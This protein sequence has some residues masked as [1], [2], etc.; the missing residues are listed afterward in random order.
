MKKWII[1]SACILTFSGY[2]AAQSTSAKATV[3]PTAKASKKG[4]EA[5]APVKKSN[6]KTT[7]EPIKLT[8][9]RFND[10]DTLTSVP[11]SGRR[12]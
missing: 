1:A 12:K 5:T 7:E 2:A 6:K 8:I 11:R 3:T 4:T 10:S 9:P